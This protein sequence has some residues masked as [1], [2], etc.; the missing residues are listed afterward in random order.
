ML[1]HPDHCYQILLSH[2]RRFDGRFYVAVRTTRIYC[3]PVCPVPPPKRQN[4]EFYPCDAAAAEAGFR[5]CRRCRPE[6]APGTAAGFD[7]SL[8][9][10]RAL[11]L[12]ANGVL[13][14]D[15]VRGLSTR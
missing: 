5:P 14:E 11:Q 15:G 8:T 1:L 13:D 3:R 9:V 6:L 2:D 12:I 7:T 10:S 4:V